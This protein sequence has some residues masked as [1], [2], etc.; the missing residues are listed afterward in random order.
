MKRGIPELLGKT[1]AGVVL[2]ENSSGTRHE[3]LLVFADDTF[4]EFR[5]TALAG[6]AGLD[7]GNLKA[8]TSYA[9][10]SGCGKV[11]VHQPSWTSAEGVQAYQHPVEAGFLDLAGEWRASAVGA[12][13]DRALPLEADRAGM[14]CLLIA[15]ERSALLGSAAKKAMRDNLEQ[16]ARTSFQT[17]DGLVWGLCLA[18]CDDDPGGSGAFLSLSLLMGHPNSNM[19]MWGMQLGWM[20]RDL[21]PPSSVPVLLRNVADTLG[22]VSQ[23]LGL[24]V[25]CFRSEAEFLKAADAFE[26]PKGFEEQ[27]AHR[28]S[29]ARKLGP[30]CCQV[31]FLI[32]ELRVRK[33]LENRCLAPAGPA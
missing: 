12:G 29:E 28:L 15:K 20:V 10:L 7:R 16:R 21:L 27:Y 14:A 32:E 23:A 3:L 24:A 6:G 26:P 19:R 31:D 18:C 8:A 1:I 2:A 9:R 11:K 33:L 25:A 4:F 30:E 22:G 17:C 5:G 13:N